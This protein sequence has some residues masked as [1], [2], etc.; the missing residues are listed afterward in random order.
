[1]RIVSQ[2]PIRARRWAGSKICDL[3]WK[4]LGLGRKK[5]R[6]TVAGIA[7]ARP[8]RNLGWKRR[9]VKPAQPSRAENPVRAWQKCVRAQE[10]AVR[11]ISG[12]I[13]CWARKFARSEEHTSELQSR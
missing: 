13:G 8:F 7:V 9:T 3:A 6:G 2:P 12:R 1:M 4:G 11:R 10:I 5:T